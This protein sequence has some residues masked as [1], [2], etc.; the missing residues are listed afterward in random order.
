MRQ[1][2]SQAGSSTAAG[3]SGGTARRVA[4]TE[5]TSTSANPAAMPA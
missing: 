2:V 4:S 1:T 5:P 3:A